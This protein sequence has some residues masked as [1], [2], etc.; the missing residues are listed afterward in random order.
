MFLL[1]KKGPKQTGIRETLG[2]RGACAG[3]GRPWEQ[4]RACRARGTQTG[5]CLPPLHRSRKPVSGG[6]GTCFRGEVMT[7]CCPG[8]SP[9]RP[10]NHQARS[11]P[12]PGRHPSAPPSLRGKDKRGPWVPG[13]HAPGSG[14]NPRGRP[15]RGSGGAC[16]QEARGARGPSSAPQGRPRS[17]GCRWRGLRHRL[18]PALSG[19]QRDAASAWDAEDTLS[20]SRQTVHLLW[21]PALSPVKGRHMALP[22]LLFHG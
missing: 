20:L 17:Q 7:E 22:G 4:R 12:G 13:K 14:L 11:G 1:L 5:A 19:P 6:H 9:P 16:S 15:L 8:W 3:E 21:A 18:P 2:Q 10:S